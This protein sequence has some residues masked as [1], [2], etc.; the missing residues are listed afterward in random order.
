MRH[1]KLR[2]RLAAAASLLIA[3]FTMATMLDAGVASANPPPPTLGTSPHW[4]LGKPEQIRDAGSDTTYFLMQRL[5]DL[6]MQSGLY[7]CQLELRHDP[8]LQRLSLGIERCDRY[9]GRQRQLRPH[10]DRDRPRE[11]RVR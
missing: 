9:D 8:E 11:D 10:R 2:N 6:Y 4:Y 3:A 7:G 1:R 5:S